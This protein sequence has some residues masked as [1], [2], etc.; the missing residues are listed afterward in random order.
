[1]NYSPIRSF[2]SYDDAQ[3]AAQWLDAHSIPY[4]ITSAPGCLFATVCAPE[5]YAQRALQLIGTQ[6]FDP[7]AVAPAAGVVADANAPPGD[8][9]VPAQ[10]QQLAACV[11]HELASRAHTTRR[12][13]Q[14]LMVLLFTLLLFA[15]F[16]LF[17]KSLTGVV[18]LTG[19]LLMH[20]LGH[21]IG[22]KLLNYTDVQM[23]FIPLFGAAV[24][25][26][27]RTPSG[28]A[29]AVVCLL[30]PVPGIVIGM[31]AGLAYVVTNEPLLAMAAKT[32][33]FLNT[34]NLLP[35]H[36][37]DGG[38]VLDAAIFLNHPRREAIF[39]VITGVL[40]VAVS[41]VLRAILLGIFAVLSLLTVRTSYR[42]A[43]IA[44]TL[45]AE[46]EVC[47]A[48]TEHD[49]PAWPVERVVMMVCQHLPARQQSFQLVAT[50][51]QTVWERVRA[52]PCSTG[53]AIALLVL[54]AFF[55]VIGMAAF[56]GVDII[57]AARG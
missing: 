49:M 39:K 36:P 23:F 18:V 43:R 57:T 10:P 55:V 19:A 15:S 37:L 44:Q 54:Y 40:L 56:V 42:L 28:A 48:T 4:R 27:A 5:E 50:H 8:A 35:F 38:R 3:S 53:A 30:G 45:R 33:V 52:K 26:R 24:S 7:S 46:P 17:S 14:Q 47:A 41:A 1:M 34:F 20:E 22:M 51:V 31:M 13:F 29:H 12:P 2:A 16:G 21:Y 6:W 25:G 32:F 9:A 11:V